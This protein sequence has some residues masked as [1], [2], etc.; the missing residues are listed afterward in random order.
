MGLKNLRTPVG[1]YN[2]R[3]TFNSALSNYPELASKLQIS[4]WESGE[5][6]A[7]IDFNDVR[8]PTSLTNNY[9]TGVWSDTLV[10][11]IDED[12]KLA[13]ATTGSGNKSFAFAVS[14][15]DDNYCL[16]YAYVQ[17]K[18]YVIDGTTSQECY[19]QTLSSITIDNNELAINY[20]YTASKIYNTFGIITK[21]P[22]KLSGVLYKT[23]EDKYFLSMNLGS[24]YSGFG[25]NWCIG[26]VNN[27]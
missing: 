20:P 1:T 15:G 21:C 19:I 14:Y 7:Y 11:Y 18:L 5:T 12:N 10:L 8:L 9:Q 27:L 17:N 23:T 24:E 3:D 25:L 4:Q 16:D 6:Y 2:S 26:N 22:A 13:F